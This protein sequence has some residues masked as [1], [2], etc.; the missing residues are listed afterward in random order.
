MKT[1]RLNRL[2]AG[3]ERQQSAFTAGLIGRTLPVLFEKSGR[4]DGSLVGRSPYM[5]PVTV[6]APVGLLG[7]IAPVLIRT[8]GP[9]SLAGELQA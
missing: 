2:L 8:A 9:N 3:M 1:L 4:N 7:A 5:Y 6:D